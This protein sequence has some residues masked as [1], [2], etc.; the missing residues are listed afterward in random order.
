[1]YHSKLFA[2]P[3]YNTA[4]NSSRV[5]T[6][7]LWNNISSYGKSTHIVTS[8]IRS[9]KLCSTW[10]TRL[11]FSDKPMNKKIAQIH[12][13]CWTNMNLDLFVLTLLWS[14]AKFQF[15]RLLWWHCCRPQHVFSSWLKFSSA[16]FERSQRNH[17]LRDGFYYWR[18]KL[19]FTRRP[20]RRR[21]G[22]NKF[23][24]C[25][26]LFQYFTWCSESWFFSKK[27]VDHSVLILVDANIK[28]TK[29]NWGSLRTMVYGVP[30]RSKCTDIEM[31]F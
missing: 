14:L 15:Q 28:T 17:L 16:L 24:I 13:S 19:E 21:L 31:L 11:S 18:K 7:N 26:R 20:S 1:M 6:H 12:L 3:Q 29:K 8:T 2:A 5:L 25:T 22:S 10:E 23:D 30:L 9:K 4:V 27:D